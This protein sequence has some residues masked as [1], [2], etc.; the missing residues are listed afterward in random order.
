MNCLRLFAC[1]VLVSLS[2][3]HAG[4]TTRAEFLFAL[5]TAVKTHDFPAMQQC[6]NLEGADFA[7]V[8]SIRKT[9]EE[10]R[11]WP[12]PHVFTS[13]RGPGEPLVINRDGKT[14]V[15]NGTWSFQ[16]HIHKSPP[17]SR[18]FVLPAGLAPSGDYKI[19]VTIPKS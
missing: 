9:L 3:L 12:S 5:Q 15:L 19:L 14:Y 17:P 18:G 7:M 2:A 16:V 4:E 8:E 10:I 6:F 11:T 1:A 13:E